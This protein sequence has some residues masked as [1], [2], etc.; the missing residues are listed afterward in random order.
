VAQFQQI[1]R[2]FQRPPGIALSGLPAAGGAGQ[3]PVNVPGVGNLGGG[4][5]G[6][7]AP[8]FISIPKPVEFPAF[9]SFAPPAPIAPPVPRNQINLSEGD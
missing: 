8:A 6:F 9:R 3:G 5:A 1:N 4:L 7:S 2:F